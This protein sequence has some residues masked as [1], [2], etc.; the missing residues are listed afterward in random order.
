MIWLRVVAGVSCAR[1]LV[2]GRSTEKHLDFFLEMLDELEKHKIVP[3]VVIDGA[4]LVA[5]ENC[6]AQRKENR[7]R[8]RI[9]AEEAC[10]A[11]DVAAADT[12]FR[13]ALSVTPKMVSRLLKELRRRKVDFMVAPYEADAQLAFLS[14]QGVV[15]LVISED[16][17]AIVYGCRRVVGP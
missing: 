6:D 17:D 15:D 7:N 3:L 11:G 9:L 13:R 16:S 4:S 1:D 8:Y 10:E 5:K 14:V 12:F 2:E